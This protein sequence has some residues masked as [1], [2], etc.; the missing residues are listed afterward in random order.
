VEPPSGR[1]LSGGVD[2]GALHKPKRFFG[3]ARK[4]EEGGS[5][6]IMATALVETGSR[7]DEVIFEEFKGTG[8]MELHLDRKLAD[9]RIFP[10]IDIIRSGTRKEEL[11]LSPKELET[12][13]VLRKVLSN[14]GPAETMELVLDRL[15]HTKSNEDLMD[16][17]LKSSFAENFRS[18]KEK[19]NGRE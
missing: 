11:L 5:L 7:M 10:A 19:S 1:T 2:P 16:L 14:L 18:K 4:L 13:W 9:R 15:T 17:I 8:N 3:A 12:T 6:T